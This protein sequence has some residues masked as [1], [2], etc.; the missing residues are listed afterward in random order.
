[1]V[2]QLSVLEGLSPVPARYHERAS[3]NL[4]AH[5]SPLALIPYRV[6]VIYELAIIL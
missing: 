6:D 2:G 5:P 3:P 4:S 1:M